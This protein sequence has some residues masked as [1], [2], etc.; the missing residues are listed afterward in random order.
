MTFAG[1]ARGNCMWLSLHSTPPPLHASAAYSEVCG[2]VA[3]KRNMHENNK[4]S[5]SVPVLLSSSVEVVFIETL[6]V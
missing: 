6:D 1:N 3:G 5:L 4:K 2:W